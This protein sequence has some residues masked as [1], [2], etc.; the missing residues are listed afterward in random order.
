MSRHAFSLLTVKTL[1][2]STMNRQSNESLLQ[3]LRCYRQHDVRE[4]GGQ[5]R[6]YKVVDGM[7]QLIGRKNVAH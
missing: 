7:A 3:N 4:N 6:R 5:N 2:F 1:L